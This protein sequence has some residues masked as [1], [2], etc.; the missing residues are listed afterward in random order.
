[1]E[2][3]VCGTVHW[4]S[5]PEQDRRVGDT[6]YVPIKWLSIVTY[7]NVYEGCY[8]HSLICHVAILHVKTTV[9]FHPTWRAEPD[10]R[11]TKYV[12]IS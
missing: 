3:T 9:Y 4:R 2:R 12:H 6:T 8:E 7:V 11:D 10:F 1:M 5:A